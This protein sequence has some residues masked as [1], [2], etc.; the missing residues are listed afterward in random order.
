MKK[1]I[2]GT[3]AAFNNDESGA[4]ATEYI[5]LLILVACF[6]IAAVK[7]FGSTVSSKFGEAN[8]AV[9]GLSFN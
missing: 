9:E 8:T 4:T 7:M 5:I 2:I 1:Q 3:L 6:V